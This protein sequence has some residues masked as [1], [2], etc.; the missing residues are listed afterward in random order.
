MILKRKDVQVLHAVKETIENNFRKPITIHY[1]AREAGLSPV[2]LQN[3]FKQLF[4][5]PVYT[6][7]LQLRMNKAK[8]LLK[9]TDD[10]IKEIAGEAGYKSTSSF[11]TAFKKREKMTPTE[12]RNLRET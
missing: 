5:V 6:Y 10:S 8:E 4:H 1:L 11:A 7:L 9:Q 3:G 12:Y 2:K